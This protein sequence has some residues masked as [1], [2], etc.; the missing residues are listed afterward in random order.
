MVHD[1]TFWSKTWEA[2]KRTHKRSGKKKYFN[3]RENVFLKFK[4]LKGF[5]FIRQL[6]TV[7]RVTANIQ[8]N[9]HN[10]FKCF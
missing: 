6:N 9:N 10:I 1:R 4:E 7:Y 5:N 3:K 2:S 8:I